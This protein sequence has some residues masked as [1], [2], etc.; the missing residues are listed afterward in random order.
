MI[1]KN[2]GLM[3]NDLARMTCGHPGTRE[4]PAAAQRDDRT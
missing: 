4:V 3:A 1:G 2:A